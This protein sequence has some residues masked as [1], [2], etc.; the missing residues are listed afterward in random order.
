MILAGCHRQRLYPSCY[1]YQP[2]PDMANKQ[3]VSG[4]SYSPKC[5][6]RVAAPPC[7]Y[8]V[9]RRVVSSEAP[10][11]S[12]VIDIMFSMIILFSL[13]SSMATIIAASFSTSSILGYIQPC[14]FLTIENLQI[15][16]TLGTSSTPPKEKESSTKSSESHPR[17]WM[18]QDPPGTRTSPGGC[19]D[20]QYMNVV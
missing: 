10:M 4:Q 3:L 15:M 20:I 17:P 9:T 5:V 19:G 11:W 18:W 7:P 8:H 1:G 13:K 2:W 6:S 14:H 12:K 16:E